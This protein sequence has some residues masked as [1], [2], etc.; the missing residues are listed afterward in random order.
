MDSDS[1][2]AAGGQK[3]LTKLQGRLELGGLG[4]AHTILLSQL[5]EACP[6][7]SLQA[8]M[9]RQETCRQIDDIFSRCAG[10]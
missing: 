5:M 10:P 8:T 7:Q 1:L 2:F 6:S 3:S 9:L 4:I